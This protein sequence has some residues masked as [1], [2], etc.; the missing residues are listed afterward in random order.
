MLNWYT[1]HIIDLKK[2]TFVTVLLSVHSE[3]IE[4]VKHNEKV[5]LLSELKVNFTNL[6]LK[7]I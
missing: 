1:I 4:Y 3:H 2:V 6:P 5:L 7:G